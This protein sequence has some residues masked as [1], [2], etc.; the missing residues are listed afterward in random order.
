MGSSPPRDWMRF[1]QR[2][3]GCAVATWGERTIVAV[4]RGRN[5][6]SDVVMLEEA[7]LAVATARRTQ[8]RVL[9]VIEPGAMTGERG[10][11]HIGTMFRN[12]DGHVNAW[13]T[14]VEGEGF[15][16][17]AA[18]AVTAGVRL[19]VKTSFPRSVESS[20]ARAVAWL[21]AETKAPLGEDFPAAL[22]DL[23]KSLEKPRPSSD[24]PGTPGRPP[25]DKPSA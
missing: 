16:A 20:V 1:V 12:V 24:P 23:R 21:E 11:R 8:V 5:R 19:L 2:G 15:W 22:E 17:S 18:R 25:S 4:Y 13:T 14:V 6:H 3:T 7:I 9:V 10:R